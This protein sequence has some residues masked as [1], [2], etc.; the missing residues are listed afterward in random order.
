MDCSFYFTIQSTLFFPSSQIN[1]TK[2]ASRGPGKRN[3]SCWT[4]QWSERR[5]SVSY[6]SEHARFPLERMHFA[7]YSLKVNFKVMYKY[8]TRVKKRANQHGSHINLTLTVCVAKVEEECRVLLVPLDKA[9]HWEL[10][11]PWLCFEKNGDLGTLSRWCQI[12]NIMLLKLHGKLLELK[13]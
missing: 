5:K 3:M 2:N 8:V 10:P 6:G 7:F 13:S 12:R 11:W 9:L 4:N 1:Q